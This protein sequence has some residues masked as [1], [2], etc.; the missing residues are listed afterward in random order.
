MPRL[1]MIAAIVASVGVLDAASQARAEIDYPYCLVTGGYE[2]RC[3][4][5]TLEQ[6]KASAAGGYCVT[7]FRYKPTSVPSGNR[8]PRR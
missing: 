3:D 1:L 2:G 5:S 4:Y 6:C 7:N 8:R